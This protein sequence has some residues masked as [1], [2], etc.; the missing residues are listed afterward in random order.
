[1]LG[2]ARG[3]HQATNTP[4][5]QPIIPSTSVLLCSTPIDG[6]DEECLPGI[7]HTQ[8]R[9]RPRGRRPIG[10]DSRPIKPQTHHTHSQ[11]PHQHLFCCVQ[12]QSTV[13]SEEC[14]PNIPSNR[15]NEG[16]GLGVNNQ[17]PTTQG[18]ATLSAQSAAL[19]GKEQAIQKM[20]LEKDSLVAVLSL[21][22][23]WPWQPIIHLQHDNSENK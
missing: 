18:P 22:L 12:N 10:H 23:V 16:V 15:C 14:F 19:T 20:P 8:S 7:Q 21:Q 1:V 5:P 17:S 6:P 2:E 3:S 11:S 4:H 13:P 9:R